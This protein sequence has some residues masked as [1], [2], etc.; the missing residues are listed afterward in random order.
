M[1]FSEKY[2]LP[3]REFS[4]VKPYF[5]DP[6]NNPLIFYSWSSYSCGCGNRTGWMRLS[7]YF[8]TFCCSEE[9][10]KGFED[11]EKEEPSLKFVPEALDNKSST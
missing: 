10:A 9:C 8:A 5:P 7:S 6:A 3:K 11:L 4:L 2:P 1:L